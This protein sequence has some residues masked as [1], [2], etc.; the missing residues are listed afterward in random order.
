MKIYKYPDESQLLTL[1]QRP[2]PA[3]EDLSALVAEV[4]E[5][6]ALH[7][8][9]AVREYAR[10]YEG[11]DPGILEVDPEETEAAAAAVPPALREA[12]QT[13]AA[14][15]RRFHEVQL[16][17]EPVTETA[18]G[19]RCWREVLPL[20]RVGLYI[21]GGT[22]PLFSTVLMLALP[23]AIAGCDEVV[24]CTP[25]GAGGT[26][27][28]AIL[29]AARLSG[30]HR[31]FRVGGIQAVAALALGTETLP[32]VDKIF[33]PGNRY[34]TAAKQYAQQRGTAIDMPAG[35]SEVLVLADDSAR[36][37]WVAADL[38]AQAEHGPDSQVILVTWSE[39]LAVQVAEE[40]TRQLASLPRRDIAAQALGHA[41]IIVVK[42]AEEGT[43]VSNRYAPEHL[44]IATERPEELLPKIRHAGS[45]FLGH[46][47]PESAGDYASGTNHTLPTAGYARIYGGV[48]LEDYV[49]KM[50]VQQI[51]PEGL[52]QLGPVITTMAEAEGLE[53]HA[54]AVRRRMNDD[55]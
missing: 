9:A 45:V 50:T 8:D 12:L 54:E 20:E 4:F 41:S 42:S 2:E 28:P 39:T 55:R 7:G 44:I 46:H 32:R 31:L 53:A 27:H 22:A 47:T 3:S 5:A 36:P 37:A 29:Y 38:L 25:A 19:V 1:L 15:I 11:R 14:N 17:Q 33:G 10:R 23:A 24:L 52:Q 48:S 49:K 51:T 40:T 16:P 34:V 35:P 13:A 30:V 21:P 43:A 6:V 18:P 26:V